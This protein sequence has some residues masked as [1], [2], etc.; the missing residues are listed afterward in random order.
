VYK[1]I[2]VFIFANSCFVSMYAAQHDKIVLAILDTY[3]EAR[4]KARNG[5]YPMALHLFEL[6]EGAG[7]HK[8][9]PLIQLDHAA[10]LTDFITQENIVPHLSRLEKIA[11]QSKA[12]KLLENWK[13]D[14]WRDIVRDKKYYQ[15]GTLKSEPIITTFKKSWAIACGKEYGAP[16]WSRS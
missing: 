5:N 11:R 13:R 12:K 2:F 9:F 7:A 4:T 3:Y 1:Y 8:K 14:N 10:T 16:E 15:Q 6:L